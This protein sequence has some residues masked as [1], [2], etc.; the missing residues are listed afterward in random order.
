M[1]YHMKNIDTYSCGGIFSLLSRCGGYTFRPITYKDTKYVVDFAVILC[2]PA[3]ASTTLDDAIND[4]KVIARIYKH[5]EKHNFF[6]GFKGAEVYE[7][8]ITL[9][10]VKDCQ[11]LDLRRTKEDDLKIHLLEIMQ[12]IFYRWE[13]DKQSQAEKQAAVKAAEAW[14]GVVQ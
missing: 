11:E 1:N 7:T 5:R 8:D 6:F 3:T 10:T 9:L 13:R 4:A 12:N 2:R 14:D